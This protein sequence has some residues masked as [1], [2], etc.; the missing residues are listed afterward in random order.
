MVAATI[1]IIYFNFIPLIGHTRSF[2]NGKGVLKTV[3]RPPRHQIHEGFP[4]GLHVL[5][6]D[7]IRFR[8]GLCGCPGMD[9]DF[10]QIPATVRRDHAIEA[11]QGEFPNGLRR[12]G[13]LLDASR[14]VSQQV[15]GKGFRNE[16]I[17]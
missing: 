14:D 13:V 9:V 2:Q 6:E 11:R 4:K 1:L 17:K 10:E 3:Q 8:H 7:G 16:Q 5:H 12:R 15:L